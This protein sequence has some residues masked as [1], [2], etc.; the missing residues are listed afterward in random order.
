MTDGAK[1][2]P[3]RVDPGRAGARRRR[4]AEAGRPGTAIVGDRGFEIAGLRS[5]ALTTSRSRRT[6]IQAPASSTACRLRASRPATSRCVTASRC[7][8]KPIR[9]RTTRPGVRIT[10]QHHRLA[11]VAGRRARQGMAE[12]DAGRRRARRRHGRRPISRSATAP[13]STPRPSSSPATSTRAAIRKY[14]AA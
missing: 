5:Q 13:P 1:F 9:G 3:G 10:A 2:Q 14:R 12:D 6:T 7:W 11:A 8:S 4:A